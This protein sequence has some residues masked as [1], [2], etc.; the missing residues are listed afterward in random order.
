MSALRIR[1]LLL[2]LCRRASDF[3]AGYL[4]FRVY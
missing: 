2:K 3:C 4:I 1:L